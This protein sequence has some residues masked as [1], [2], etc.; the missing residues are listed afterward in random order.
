MKKV[1]AVAITVM[2][3]EHVLAVAAAGTVVDH[4]A[5]TMVVQLLEAVDLDTL[6]V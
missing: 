4:Q 5:T 1:V 6:V 3:L 2:R